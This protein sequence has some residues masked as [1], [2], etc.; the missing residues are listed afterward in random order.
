MATTTNFGWETPDD[1][2]LVKDGA[3]AIRTLGSAI[4]TSLVDLKGGTTGQFLSKASDTDLDYTWAVPSVGKDWTLINTGGTT[5]TGSATVTISGLTGYNDLII[6]IYN[7]SSASANSQLSVKYNAANQTMSQNEN[8][9]I[10]GS[11]Y[12]AANF[13]IGT[14]AS[15]NTDIN[16]A[17]MANNAASTFMGT[18]FL[19]GATSS[20]LKPYMSFGG[21][22][23][24]GGTGHRH[25][26]MAGVINASAISS[27]SVVSDT[28]NFDKG[29]AYVW[30]SL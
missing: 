21:A 26:I 28:G 8:R 29:T 20:T 19:W 3:A 13:D 22:D 16:L 6:G 27:I 17:S 23:A 9:L 25:K 30:G 24:G 10:A 2:D 5:L 4:D 12:S 11:T 15:T 1:T 7:A 14:N 18:V